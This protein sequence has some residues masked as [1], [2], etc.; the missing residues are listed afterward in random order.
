MSRRIKNPSGIHLNSN[1]QM[2][3]KYG[4]VLETDWDAFEK[5]RDKRVSPAIASTKSRK[6]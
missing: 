5:L 3:D 6:Q 1:G 2:V 4:R